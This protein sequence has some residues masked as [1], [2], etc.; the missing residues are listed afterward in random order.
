[1][2]KREN[3]YNNEVIKINLKPNSNC[4]M[5][6]LLCFISHDEN[7]YINI[8]NDIFKHQM[9]HRNEMQ[10]QKHKLGALILMIVKY[11]EKMANWEENWK[12]LR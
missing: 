8:R 10:N 12:Y 7:K 9:I 1:M 2:L 4:L 5:R 6:C 3:I 11:I